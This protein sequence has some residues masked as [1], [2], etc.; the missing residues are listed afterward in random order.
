MTGGG[1]TR[2]KVGR[3]AGGFG[4]GGARVAGGPGI[5]KTSR[6]VS[7]SRPRR[8]ISSSVAVGGSMARR[9]SAF[10]RLRRVISSS[11][12][13]ATATATAFAVAFV[14]AFATST[15]VW[16]GE[17]EER[18]ENYRRRCEDE[19]A[20]KI[21]AA[22]RGKATREALS[23]QHK[24]AVSIQAAGRGQLTRAQLQ[25]EQRRLAEEVVKGPW[26]LW[27]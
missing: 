27:L 19:A 26:F 15:S 25:A 8:V 1:P 6:I 20:T 10:S 4:V 9:I 11:V 14:F 13:T 24:A 18:R 23:G 22:K 7:F 17:R 12:S 5:T 21:Q 3:R 16:R 2:M